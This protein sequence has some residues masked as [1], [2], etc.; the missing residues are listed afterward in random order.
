MYKNIMLLL[1][2]MLTG[3]AM[4]LAF[5]HRAGGTNPGDPPVVWLMPP[6]RRRGD[7]HIR[8]ID[9]LS[10]RKKN[11]TIRLDGHHH[12]ERCCYLGCHVGVYHSFDQPMA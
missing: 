4:T 2:L 1:T 9:C 10:H 6:Y 8:P 11:R 12:L 3:R 7:W 5:I